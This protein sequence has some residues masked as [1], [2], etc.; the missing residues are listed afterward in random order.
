[1][2]LPGELSSAAA[3]EEARVRRVARV[4]RPLACDFADGW[5]LVCVRVR[6]ERAGGSSS[7]SEEDSAALLVEALVA[8][9]LTVAAGRFRFRLRLRGGLGG[10]R[11]I[12]SLSAEEE[13]EIYEL[14]SR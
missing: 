1:M 5:G 7:S 13:G 10:A 6:L 14:Q 8:A 12:H 4:A 11:W 3:G 2:L 9:F